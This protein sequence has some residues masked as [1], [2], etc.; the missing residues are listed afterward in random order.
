[1][2]DR[3]MKAARTLIAVRKLLR[4]RPPRSFLKMPCWLSRRREEMTFLTCEPTVSSRSHGHAIDMRTHVQT[5]YQA[6]MLTLH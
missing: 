4:L 5:L 2:L 3:Y 6:L 1:M